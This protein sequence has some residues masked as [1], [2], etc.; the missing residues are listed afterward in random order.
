MVR[1]EL[2]DRIATLQKTP[3]LDRIENM[4]EVLVSA[5]DEAQEIRRLPEWA[6]KEMIDAGLYRFAMPAELA[7]EDFLAKEQIETLEA[8]AAIDGS[9]GWCVSINSEINSLVLRKIPLDLAEKICDDWNML[10]CSGQGYANGPNPGRE[11]HRE[12]EGWQLTYQ[13]SF[14]SGCHNATYAMVF[15]SVGVPDKTTG[16][17]AEA[18][19]VIP[20]GEF[21]IIDTWDMAGLRGTG[22]HDVRIEQYVPPEHVLPLDALDSSDLWENPTYRNPAQVP[23]NKGAVGL[24]IARGVMDEFIK[25][26]THKTPWGSGTLLKE[27]PEAYIRIG[28]AEATYQAAR[29]FLINS[30]ERVEEYLGPLKGGHSEPSTE[31]AQLALLSSTHAAQAMRHVVDTIHNTAGTTASRMS[32]PLERKLRD[33]HQAAAHGAI[34]YRNYGNVGKTLLGE[35]PPQLLTKVNRA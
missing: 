17:T 4:R 11:A 12:G 18:S 22:S 35:E 19:W 1:Q 32:H 25:L 6:A 33:A 24:G 8:T 3:M 34:S 28:E 16:E 27:Q 14:A 10:V 29:A 7:G 23:Y 21:E 15:D 13:G 20:Q 31:L 2:K 9:I 5:A 30:Q 26:A